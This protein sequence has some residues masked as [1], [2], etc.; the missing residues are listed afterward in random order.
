MLGFWSRR[1][2][3]WTSLAIAASGC[4][5]I[6]GWF[7][8]GANGDAPLLNEEELVRSA[9]S[10]AEGTFTGT[11]EARSFMSFD[12]CTAPGKLLRWMVLSM[13]GK[14]L[15]IRIL[16]GAALAQLRAG[17]DDAVN[18]DDADKALLTPD[19]ARRYGIEIGARAR[20]TGIYAPLLFSGTIALQPV[21]GLCTERIERA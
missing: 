13:D 19:D 1:R 16:D 6:R 18:L 5:T 20:I 4:Q 3:V 14:R 17:R 15:P 10:P 7:E 9:V 8:E 11:I 2:F 12:G 21:Y